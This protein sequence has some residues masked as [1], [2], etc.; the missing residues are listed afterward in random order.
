MAKRLHMTT[1]DYMVIAISPA[2]IMTLV[3][4][5]V[6]FLLE[7]FYGGK[8]PDRLQFCLTMFVFAAV[9]VGR[10]SIEDGWERAAPFGLALAAVVMLA[11]HKFVDYSGTDWERYGGL[12]NLGLIALTWWCANQLTWDCTLIDDTQDASGEGL[13]QTVG[14]DAPR[15]AAATPL[16]GREG[17]GEGRAANKRKAKQGAPEELENQPS[18]NLSLQGRGVSNEPEGT[19]SRPAAMRHWWWQSAQAGHRPHTPGVWVIYF[20]LAA[21]P[22]FGLGQLLI[23]T[24]KVESQRYVFCLFCV[25][26]A[27]GLG[28]LL[29]TS[30]LGLR[31]Y[32]RQRRLQMPVAMAGV[33]L[34]IGTVLIAAVLVLAALL[35]RTNAEYPIS[36][37]PKFGSPNQTSSEHA[38]G[39]EGVHE[40]NGRKG[41]AVG[42][43]QQNNDQQQN[44]EGESSPD[45]NQPPDDVEQRNGKQP[46]A[47][48]K[49]AESNPQDQSSGDKPQA[50]QDQ[51]SSRKPDDGSQSRP[52]ESSRSEPEQ[53]LNEQVRPAEPAQ[54][55]PPPLPLEAPLGWLPLVKW[56]FYLC[57]ACGGAYAAWCWRH[58]VF[59]WLSRLAESW[60]EFWA[61]LFGLR[62]E[63]ADG[64]ADAAAA[65]PSA[66]QRRFADFADPYTNGNA[67]HWPPR[68]LVR[69]SFEAFEAWAREQGFPRAPDQT[70][71]ELARQVGA[72]IAAVSRESRLL[73]DLYSR[74]AFA[75]G[76]PLV[77][78]EHLRQLWRELR[79]VEQPVGQR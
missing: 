29:T 37:L 46:T 62:P 28:L 78:I 61:T 35:P 31:R 77:G 25:Y 36:Q 14:L 13:L 38:Q 56:L 54:P 17:S 51:N 60:R 5:L 75:P 44:S 72:R 21:L 69:Y 16:P 48:G 52:P 34:G 32:L 79:T 57:L 11:L 71:H 27:S 7:L 66:R 30:F 9:L 8:S 4:S 50:G 22:I 39:D 15:G 26:V 76:V 49:S 64:P 23:P 63:P 59:A 47:D 20:S 68:E 74:V 42:E 10:I 2:L 55:S 18:P 41:R 33:W 67:Q 1:A 43:P 70:P 19:T 12:I 58:E 24:G 65:A 3:G 6:Y 40:E 53:H 73:A 45:A